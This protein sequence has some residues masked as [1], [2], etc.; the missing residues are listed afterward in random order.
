M[1]SNLGESQSELITPNGYIS[2]NHIQIMIH[3]KKIHIGV[4]LH[5]PPVW[6]PVAH[7][8]GSEVVYP[9]HL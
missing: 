3:S 4:F 6:N 1:V 7:V 5:D 8:D 9:I 2:F